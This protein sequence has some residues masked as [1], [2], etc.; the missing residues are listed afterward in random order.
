MLINDG[1]ALDGGVAMSL[2]TG[3]GER[4]SMVSDVTCGD[5]SGKVTSG[6]LSGEFCG[7]GSDFTGSLTLEWDKVLCGGGESFFFTGGESF[8][9]TYGEKP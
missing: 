8:F 1:M 4:L 9:L 3:D 6:D 7:G 2:G 5:V